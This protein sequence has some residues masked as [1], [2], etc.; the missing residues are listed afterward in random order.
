MVLRRRFA[1]VHVAMIPRAAPPVDLAAQLRA[2][3]LHRT[4]LILSPDR[5][6]R[7]P[8]GLT[9]RRP[10]RI[11]V[12]DLGRSEH[13]LRKGLHP[14]WRNQLKRG[15][16]AD[17][18][19]RRSPLPADP[20]TPVLRR[21]MRQAA[22]RG[23]VNWPAPL[24]AAFAATAPAQTHLITATRKGR[25]VAMM[26]FLTHGTCVSYQIGH[27]GAEGRTLCAHNLLMWHAICRFRRQGFAQID[28][29]QL[30]PR[31]ASLDRFKLRC[32]ARAVKTG[33]TRLYWR[34]FAAG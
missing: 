5:P 8:A 16:A 11:A 24:T 30:D 17:L 28:L 20:D 27:I 23:Y 25:C 33:G 18:K 12:L 1:G 31:T 13:D 22:A 4:P 26:L 29:G 32:G 21:E 7:M 15:E 14:K 34:P 9:L 2:A 10:R 19:V 3:G 6:S